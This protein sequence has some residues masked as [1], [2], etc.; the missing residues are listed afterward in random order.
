LIGGIVVTGG[1]SKLRHLKQL[2]EYVT[3]MDTKI[4][5]PVEHL[6][7]TQ[8]QEISHPMYATSIGLILKGYEDE[9][10]IAFAARQD[11][12]EEVEV[13]ADSRE[14]SEA[15]NEENGRKGSWFSSIITNTRRWF[16]EDEVSDFNN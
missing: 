7:K 13:T 1:G 12:T 10:Y 3:G 8:F 5:F 2:V 16:E 15:N 4:G 11:A 6:T 14:Q 9:R